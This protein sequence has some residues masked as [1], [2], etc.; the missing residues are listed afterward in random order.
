MSNKEL[1]TQPN[2]QSSV[3]LGKK[4]SKVQKFS[5]HAYVFSQEISRGVALLTKKEKERR[6][7]NSQEDRRAKE[8]TRMISVWQAQEA[9]NSGCG[10]RRET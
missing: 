9:T 5:S 2:Y 4:G 7:K 6:S 8:N 10:A 1:F 3:R